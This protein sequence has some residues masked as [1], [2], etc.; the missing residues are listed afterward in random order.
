MRVT[1]PREVEAFL[2]GRVTCELSRCQIRRPQNVADALKI[3]ERDLAFTGA[4]AKC[5]QD[6]CY[7]VEQC[8]RLNP[9]ETL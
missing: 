4:F 8:E 1:I 5:E 9:C 2:A 6:V 7:F 3:G